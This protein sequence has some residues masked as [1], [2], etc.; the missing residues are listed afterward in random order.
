MTLDLPKLLHRYVDDCGYSWPLTVQVINRMLGSSYTQ[1]QLRAL[2]GKNKCVQLGHRKSRSLLVFQR[3]RLHFCGNL[4]H[5]RSGSAKLFSSVS[6][7][8]L[9]A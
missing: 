2:Y 6:E 8:P 4:L 5:F 1:E 9:A 7:L 3:K